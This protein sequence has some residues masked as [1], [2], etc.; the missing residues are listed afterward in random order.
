LTKRASELLS[1][2]CFSLV[3]GL[4]WFDRSIDFFIE[5]I[6][7][8]SDMNLDRDSRLLHCRRR[9]ARTLLV[10]AFLFAVC[11]MPYNF[12]NLIIDHFDKDTQQKINIKVSE[13]II[14]N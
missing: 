7:V 2:F 11:W 1:L 14:M 13:S 5:L 10:L 3:F 8:G 9:V 4:I 12:L 6:G